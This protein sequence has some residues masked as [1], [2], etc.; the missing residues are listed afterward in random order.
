M[1]GTVRR[2]TRRAWAGGRAGCTDSTNGAGGT[3]KM[4]IEPPAGKGARNPA[5]RQD[6]IVRSLAARHPSG[7]DRPHAASSAGRVQNNLTIDKTP[8]AHMH[9]GAWGTCIAQ[10][11]RAAW[12]LGSR[13]AT[14]SPCPARPS[15]AQPGPPRHAS[16]LATGRKVSRPISVRHALLVAAPRFRRFRGQDPHR[17][18]PPQGGRRL[19]SCHAP[20]PPGRIER[21]CK[22][23]RSICSSSLQARWGPARRRCCRFPANNVPAAVQ[24]L[25]AAVVVLA[26]ARSSKA[27]TVGV[28]AVPARGHG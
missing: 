24:L 1:E 10:Q 19:E 22:L 28:A 25:L 16:S 26:R 8:H 11:Q 14:P 7:P 23:S 17:T 2:A 5:A 12:P 18:A 21:T 3:K 13:P 20:P 6:I 15:Q 27:P 4:R 9:D